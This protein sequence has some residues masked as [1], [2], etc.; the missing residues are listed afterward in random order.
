[1]LAPVRS[2]VMVGRDRELARL[3]AA[4]LAAVRGDSKVAVVRG[5]TGVGKS[6]LAGEATTVAATLGMVALRGECSE[7]DLSSPYL[8]IVEAIDA[9]LIDDTVRAGLRAAL[10][11]D[12]APLAR[13]LPQLR[14]DDRFDT[15]GT[16]LDK[17][18]L[19]ESVV[20]MLRAIAARRGL[21]LLV[22]D[23]HWA[24]P[25]TLELLDH[26]VRRLHS[27]GTLLVLTLRES[28][29][30]RG[31]PL[32]AAVQ[33]W[34][35]GGADALDLQPLDVDDLAAMTSAILDVE[36]TPHAVATRLHE[37]TDGLPL[38]VEELLRQAIELGIGD[39]SR[40]GWDRVAPAGVPAP[41]TL[42]DA[43]L[44]RAE[45]LSRE[46]LEVARAAAVLGRSFDFAALQQMTTLPDESLIEML[47]TFSEMQLIEEDQRR[48]NGYRFRHILIRDAIYNDILVSR[49]RRMHAH[50]AEAVRA[51]RPDDPSELAHHLI[52][53][54][55]TEEA[56]RA[57]VDAAEAALRHLAPRD[58]M[59]LFAQALAHSSEAGDRARLRC[60]LGEAA[61][62]AGDIPAAQEHLE[63]GVTALEDLGDA[64]TAAH[65][66]LT[67]GRCFWL[68]SDYA[69]AERQ[70]E[71]A[72]AG[73]EGAGPSDDLA[74]AYIRLSGLHAADFEAE[75]AEQLGERAIVIAEQQGSIEQ[76]VA[77]ADW[78]GVAMCLAGKLDAGIAE[79]ER[80]RNAARLRGLHVLESTAVIH[81]LSMLET[82]GRVATCPPLIER[83][84]A[85]PE[86]P[87][88]SVVT[89]YYES[90]LAFWSAELVAAARAA[91]RC[92]DL[93][94]GFG[95]QGQ[96]GWGRGLLCLVATELGD[97]ESA[98]ELLPERTASLQ[99][100]ERVEQG[101]VAMRFHLATD[102]LEQAGPIASEFAAEPW[103]VA[104]TAL[105]DAVVYA[106]LALERRDE[107]AGF[108]EALAAHPRAAMHPGQLLRSRGRLALDRG[109]AAVAAGL[110]TPAMDA[111][112]AGGYRLEVLRTKVLL[113]RALALRGDLPAAAGALQEVVQAAD[114]SRAMLIARSA[115][116]AARALGI[117]AGA[118][119]LEPVTL[120]SALGS[121]EEAPPSRA[122][123]DDTM[124]A[125]VVSVHDPDATAT[126]ERAAAL[127]RWTS[128]AVEQHHGVIDVIAAESIAASFNVSGWHEDH[129]RHA[130]DATLE[131]LRGAERLGVELSGGIA[132][133]ARAAGGADAPSAADVA[134]RLFAIARRGEV[135]IAEEAYLRLRE[136]LPEGAGP[137]EPV[138][139]PLDV[140][141]ALLPA[142]RLRVLQ[143][144]LQ[145]ATGSRPPAPEQNAITR[146]GEFWTLSYG[147]RVVHLKDTKGLRDLSRLLSNPGA[148][149][150]AVD[151]AGVATPVPAGRG[152]AAA[153]ADLA[154]QGDAGELLDERARQ[155]Y[156]QRLV[157]LEAEVN[158]AEASND[159]ERAS[160]ARQER[161]FIIDELGAAVGLMGKSRRALD[162]AERARKAVTWRLR[163]TITRIAASDA[164]LGRHLRH[165]VR[166]GTFCVYDPAAPTR[167][168]TRV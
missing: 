62:Q 18:R 81:M 33:R 135:L 168:S 60:S 24:D 14:A 52:A 35:R 148:E 65:H 5:D 141:G 126:D 160:R 77:A 76:R 4:A 38:A 22:E 154:L 130:L 80:S 55:Q 166:T 167:W 157:D 58:A 28:E 27:S 48:D 122:A 134:V 162:P 89:P 121:D 139:V 87:W 67:L 59:E 46:Q 23:V 131:I 16:S 40:S 57:C 133:G 70:Y 111:F 109:D 136:H 37:R 158:D 79:L 72:R 49:R 100:Q 128:L 119:A 91:Q 151:L 95:M 164:E 146:E 63:L 116:S 56:A 26:I 69:E 123:T 137:A 82:Y 152:R 31:H 15:T 159:P 1:M 153:D 150:A 110:L 20:A 34:V 88:V 102:D 97:L 129:A 3:E 29:L 112:E 161:D 156:R 118:T 86:N 117:E 21:L 144:R 64:V 61:F 13:I 12:I 99:R 138:D 71:L 94:T 155:E 147:G 68:R 75:E 54:G 105:S 107:A 127:R 74:L 47:D 73:L 19:F 93:A 145:P 132:S 39:V 30:E 53:A 44:L 84:R 108:V 78:L 25:A 104:G 83:L 50:A 32:R 41:R 163:D 113:G 143:P 165:S 45:R 92:I 66:R 9:H 106:L 140:A 85:L 115:A 101:W 10:G 11:D 42:T 6:R 120:P 98:R 2:P 103:A 90:W 124:T 43:F 149:I 51:T 36:S 17:L 142:V 8:P 96:A 7:S 125:V 114:A